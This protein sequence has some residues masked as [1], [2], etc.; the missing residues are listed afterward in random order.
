MPAHKFHASIFFAFLISSTDAWG[1]HKKIEDREVT[2]YC[3]MFGEDDIQGR[4]HAFMAGNKAYYVSDTLVSLGGHETIGLTHPFH[5]DLRSR[6]TGIAYHDGVGTGNDFWGWEFHRD[7]KVA[8]GTV[9]T[10][11]MRWVNP[12]PSRMFWQPD[13]MVMEYDLA[14]PYLDGVFPG[15]CTDWEQGSDHG[16]SFWVDLEESEC[17]AH[18]EADTS[19]FQA[20]FE[21]D[22]KGQCWI[23]IN[24]MTNEPTGSRC[25]TCKDSCYAK[26]VAV[27]PV[28]VREEKFIAANDVVSTIITS[29][30]PVI[31]EVSGR[32][33]DTGNAI[34]LN[35]KCSFHPENN[36]IQVIEGGRVMAK[37]SESPPIE[38]EATLMYDG[39]SMALTASRP[40]E[41]VTLYEISPGVCGYTFFIPLDAQGF[42]MSW[43]MDYEWT[44]AIEAVLE[45]Q[46]NPSEH[47]TD[48]TTKMNNLLNN[49][50]PFF[51]CSDD[52]IVKI[53]YFLWS[54]NLLYYTQGGEGMQ[55]W[56][57]TQ[58]AVNNFLGLHRFDAVFQILVGS[59]TSP[60]QHRFYAE[61]NVLAWSELL[62]FRRNEQL[63]D[64]FGI[65]WA[66]GVYGPETIAHIIGAWQVFEHSG[67]MDYLE[68][69][70]SFYK[71]LFWDEIGG[72]HFDYGYDSVLCLNKMAEVLGY[73]DDATHW[74]ASIDMEHVMQHL[75]YFWEIDTPGMF[76]GTGGGIGW[77]QIAS[78]GISMF[79][80]EWVETMARDWLDNPVDGFNAGV[81]LTSTAMKYY[82]NNLMEDFAVVPDANWYMI[83]GLYRHT[84]DRIANKFT[85]AHLKNY[86]MEDGPELQN[87]TDMK[88][89]GMDQKLAK[90]S[91][92]LEDLCNK[93]TTQ[94]T[95]VR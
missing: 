72:N 82:P 52:D 49:V 32:S 57:H 59:W 39:M 43:A 61:G 4:K 78:S 31:L 33:F 92:F 66:S 16:D 87:V 10:D 48:K 93:C 73:S 46:S 40:M 75:E 70:Y 15:W 42:V 24:K 41:N 91:H 88:K 38:K 36:A 17:W 22:E 30:H 35:G 54:I 95:N 20:V 90:T 26:P 81:P 60:D 51:R 19:C 85:L 74:N 84:V 45:I 47:M 56:P 44:R 55:V 58:T 86:N 8:F 64:N 89:I 9:A 65:D 6:G 77:T 29:D 2:D 63:P 79:P 50:V 94:W 34:S 11:E 28:S 62:P 18:C 13:K 27:T 14:S 23:G 83:R 12:A 68:K 21:D 76:G 7:T 3:A 1:E 67:N 69:A 37:V 80:R 53:Y 71:E 5:H 25:P